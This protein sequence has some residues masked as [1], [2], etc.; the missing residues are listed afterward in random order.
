[1]RTASPGAVRAALRELSEKVSTTPGVSAASFSLGA[2]PLQNEDDLFFWLDGQPKPASHSEMKMALISQVE[3]GYLAALGIPLKRGRF[4]TAQ[5]DERSLPV[6]VIDEAFAHTYFSGDDP[7]GKRVYTEGNEPAQIVGVVGHVKQWSLD[8]DETELQAQLYFPF[9]AISDDNLPIGVGVVVRS[10]G[11]AG[12]ISSGLVNSLRRVSESQNNQNVISGAQ[13]MNEV[14]GDS[15]SQQRFSLSLLGAFAGV[16]LLL[17]SLGIY[18]VISYLVGQRT[19]ELGLRLALGAQR[20]DVLQL[21][22]SHGMKLT[23][24]GVALGLVAALG[25]TRLIAKMLYG[26]SATD[27]ITYVVITLLLVTIALLACL[28]P[29]W[30]ATQVDPLTALRDE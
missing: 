27:P 11:S 9:R 23:L 26:V 19:Q 4:F 7:I 14:I 10:D 17:A 1:M 24:A 25:L 21:I 12:N 29:A 13:T 8:A 16:A 18:G 6:A 15:L 20:R 2:A 3:P 22:L 5:D 28:A 30:R